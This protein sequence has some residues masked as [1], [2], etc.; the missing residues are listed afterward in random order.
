[1]STSLIEECHRRAREARRS[2]EA[3]SMPSKKA[4]FLE[5]EQRW[6]LAARSVAPKSIAQRKQPM[7]QQTIEPKTAPF[8]GRPTKFTPE[9]I[10]Q[11]KD[12]IAQGKSREEIAGVIDVTVGSL[13]VT[14]SKLGISLRRPRLNPQNDL[15]GQGASCSGV[16]S[17]ASQVTPVRFALPVEDKDVHQTLPGRSYEVTLAS[18]CRH[19]AKT[20]TNTAIDR[21][22]MIILPWLGRG[23]L[24]L[25]RGDHAYGVTTVRDDRHELTDSATRA[26]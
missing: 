4:N 8:K 23:S 9:R 18:K 26:S 1:M 11:I 16:N 25:T 24:N 7:T 21:M 20:A 14:C 13:Q 22:S 19:R 2:A 17:S 10:Q 6:L 3:A 5:M 12:L 15:P